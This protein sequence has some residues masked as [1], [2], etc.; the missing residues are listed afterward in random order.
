[1]LHVFRNNYIN[2]ILIWEI[3]QIINKNIKT[4]VVTKEIQIRRPAPAMAFTLS[5]F[6]FNFFIGEK[7]DPEKIVMDYLNETLVTGINGCDHSH[8]GNH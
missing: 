1:M 4:I 7:E 8:C 5:D 6:S 3:T 2:Y